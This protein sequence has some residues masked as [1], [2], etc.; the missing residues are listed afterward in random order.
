MDSKMIT[1]AAAGAAILLLA[2]MANDR[3]AYYGDGSQARYPQFLLYKCRPELFREITRL[4]RKTFYNLVKEIERFGLLK[5]GSSVSVEEQLLI[6]LDIVCNNNSMRQTAVKFCPGLYTITRYFSQVLNALV[7]LYPNYVSY[8]PATCALPNKIAKNPKYKPFKN[9]LG[10]L[11]GVFIPATVPVADQSPWRS[12]KNIIAQNV[13]AAINFN[14]EFVFVLATSAHNTRVFNDSTTKGLNITGK[15]Y[16]LA[17]AGYG[18]RQGLMTPFQGVRYHLKEQAAAGRSPSNRKELYN[19]RHA[20]LQNQVERIFGCMK[21]KFPILTTPPE[22]QLN[23]QV[24]LV[25]ALCMLWN[26]IQ[27]NEALDNLFDD[28]S[29]IPII[30]Q[31]TEEEIE[32]GLSIADEDALQKARREQIATKLFNQYVA[33]N[34]C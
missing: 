6:F 19:L 8:T 18:M 24:H 32:E 1:I 7:A 27:K 2:E 28:P 33:Y 13:L 22:F 30:T 9:C 12:R 34:S 4:E 15:K 29:K 20:T 14:F 16:F 5:N 23:K 3:E 11:D 21:R 25:Y 10:A 26:F 17:N 31:P